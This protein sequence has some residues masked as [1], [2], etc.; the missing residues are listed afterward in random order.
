MWNFSSLTRDKAH[1]PCTGR[2]SLNHWT[3]MGVPIILILEM[4]QLRLRDRSR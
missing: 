3:T 1:T 4:S 2:Q